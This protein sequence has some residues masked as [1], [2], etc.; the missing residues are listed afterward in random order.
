[1]ILLPDAMS[2]NPCIGWVLYV[3]RDNKM[4]PVSYCTAKLKDYM[5]KWYPC[6]KEAVGAVIALDQCSHWVNESQLPTLVGPDSSAVV[7]AVD[8]IKRGKH[9]SNPRLQ[10]LLASVNRRNVRFYHNSAKAGN[11]IVPDH[12]SRLTNNTC[13]SEDS[14]IERFLIDIPII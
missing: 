6:E 13:G 12:L 5:Q 8:L 9:S 4:L 3:M 2:V 11:H 1:M 10:S 14:A 7:K